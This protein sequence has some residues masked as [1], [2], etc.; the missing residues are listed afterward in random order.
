LLGSGLG[1]LA[2]GD[3]AAAAAR[4]DGAAQRF[5]DHLGSWV[6]AG[7]AYYIAGDLATSRNRFETALALDDNFAETHG[8]L[9]V[10]DL[11]EGQKDSARR[12]TEV[13][14]RLDRNCFAAALARS[15]ILD[16]EGK[17]N[18]ARKVRDAA[19]NYPIGPSGRTIA[20]SL[21]ALAPAEDEKTGQP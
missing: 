16:S 2:R 14:L 1:Q 8:A 13:A 17:S 7:W 19:L 3:A 6:A 15:M 12:R 20:R 9:A 11:V 4:L 5:G 21:A 10:L 18:A